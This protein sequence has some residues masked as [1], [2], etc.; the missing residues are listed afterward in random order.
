MFRRGDNRRTA[1][2]ENPMRA[3]SHLFLIGACGLLATGM[4]CAQAA[5]VSPAAPSDP[6]PGLSFIKTPAQDARPIDPTQTLPEVPTFHL[7]E[8]PD[9]ATQPP[10]AEEGDATAVDDAMDQADDDQGDDAGYDD[11]AYGYYDP[12]YI[13]VYDRGHDHDHGDHGHHRPGQPHGPGHRPPHQPDTAV[14]V[15]VLPPGTR[16]P[17]PGPVRVN[18]APQRPGRPGHDGSPSH[19]DP[20]R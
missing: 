2:W 3:R 10:Y 13:T 7:A 12:G 17:P 9:D 4:A 19:G 15:G 8:S 16:P 6:R 1:L 14:T 11:D 18:V 5:S 20:H